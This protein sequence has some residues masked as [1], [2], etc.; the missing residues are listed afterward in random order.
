VPQLKERTIRLL[1]LAGLI[2]AILLFNGWFLYFNFNRVDQQQTLVKQTNRLINEVDLLMSAA[3]D[4]ETGVRGYMWVKDSAYLDPY[5]SG[6]TEGAEHIVRLREMSKNNPEQALSVE[7]LAKTYENRLTFLV[8]LIEGVDNHASDTV[9]REALEDG[10][11]SMDRLRELSEQFKEHELQALGARAQDAEKA[12][13]LFFCFLILTT[14]LNIAVVAFAFRQFRVN[15]L[16]VE[17]EGFEKERLSWLR[18]NVGEVSRLVAGDVTT[19]HVA[20]EVQK[21]LVHRLQVLAANFFVKNGDQLMRVSSYAIDEDTHGGGLRRGLVDEA[22]TRDEPWVIEDIPKDYWKISSSLG[23]APP[24]HLVFLPLSFQE[25]PVG[26]IEMGFFAKPNEDQIKLLDQLSEVIGTAVNAATTREHLQELLERTQQQAEELETQQE[27]LKAN[28]EEL[29]QQARALETQQQTLNFKNKEL[30]TAQFDLE[31]KAA[32][33]ERSSQY[34]SEFLAKMSHELRTPLNG[35]LILSTLLAENKEKNLSEQQKQFAT[36][37]HS[38][39][40][41]LLLLINDILDLSKIEARKLSLKA[42]HFNLGS[43]FEQMQKTFEPQASAKKIEFKTDIPS[44]LRDK[45][46]FTDRQRL[47]QIL[48]NFL[49]NSLKFTEAGYVQ[50]SARPGD[51]GKWMEISVTDTGIGIPVN[52][53]NLIFEAFEQA[54]SSVSRKFGGTG[55]GLTISRELAA[56]LGG[57]IRLTSEEG[58]GSTFT[59]TIPV[60]LPAQ[61]DTAPVVVAPLAPPTPPTADTVRSA[62]AASGTRAVTQAADKAL[63]DL[64]PDKRTILIV[65]DDEKFLNSVMEATRN[66]DFQPIAAHDGEQALA[67]LERHVPDAILLDIKLPGISGLGL[68]EMIKHLPHLRHIPVHMISGLDYQHN[69]LRMGA[70]GYLTKPVTVEK[71]RSALD[72]IGNL[73]SQH[74]RR[75]L[76][77]EDDPRQTLAIT[78]LVAGQDVEVMAAK[79]GKEAVE[80]L[81]KNT[82]DCIILDLSLPDVSGFDFL[83]ELNSLDVSLPPIVIYTAKELSAEEETYLRKYSESIIIKGVRSPERL[84]DEVNLFLHRVESLLPEDKREML[85][86]LRSQEQNFDGKTVLVVDDDLRNIFALTSALESKGLNVRIARDGIE[87]LDALGKFPDIDVVLMDIMMPRMDGF[88]AMRHI[89]QSKDERIRSIPVI[90]LTAKAMRE[91]HEKCMEAGASD[92]LPKPVNLSNLMTSLKVW[93]APRGIFT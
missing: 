57:E 10:K 75:I 7:T 19:D 77:I 9:Q 3:K 31:S 33:L 88:E 4:A 14:L 26:V 65:E 78:N 56:L 67:I 43:L 70:L 52:K 83:A 74:V 6:L 20:S 40:N 42:E 12:R 49:S 32:D 37:I 30:E 39:G 55:L 17:R 36:S 53:R 13:Y 66:Y 41:D 54:D 35:L 24:R 5:H 82:F 85:S 34:K 63:H 45:K 79:T 1:A 16:R 38:A 48:R 90:A 71:V 18:E 47:E 21:F 76:L 68:L 2:F 81:K 23:G 44:E 59:L 61:N 60:D 80:R 72:R 46:F 69:A 91:D 8:K 62:T 25:K 84:L 15:Q 87:G 86:H 93:L 73:V 22:V 28:N 11:K 58:R 50:L 92:Y 89:R 29:E 51:G 27:E 64:K